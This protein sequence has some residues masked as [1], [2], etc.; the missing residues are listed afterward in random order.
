MPRFLNPRPLTPETPMIL[1][2]GGAG[3]I[4]SNL[5]SALDKRGERVVVCDRLGHDEKWR[6]L[7]KHYLED[8]VGPEQ[9]SDF[10]NRNVGDIEIIFHMGAIS[11][12]TETDADKIIETNFRL[13]RYL[14]HWCK[15]NDVRFVYASSAATYGNGEAGFKDEETMAALAKLRPLNAY[16]WSKHLFDR[17]VANQKERGDCGPTQCVGLKF[18]NVYGPNEYHKGSMRSVAHQIFPFALR[19]E[20]FPLFRSYNP[21]YA[22][23]GQLRDFVWVGDCVN[24]MQWLLDRPKVNGLFNMGT[25]EARSFA[26]LAKAV[27]IA[28]GKEPM[29]AYREMPEDLRPRYQYFTEADMRKLRQAGYTVPFTA[30]E[31][32]IREYVQNFLAQP[33]PYI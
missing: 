25:N 11:S 14:W 28:T 26:D 33:D 19:D 8:L 23:G 4:G 21:R 13:S 20:A 27:Y 10:L 32:G 3:F 9:I 29:L 2:T 15:E 12:T 24:V 6:N 7:A 22:D 16:G 30:L 31:D 1:I 18:F 17:W 5:V